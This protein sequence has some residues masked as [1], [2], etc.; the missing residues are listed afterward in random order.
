MSLTNFELEDL[1]KLLKMRVVVLL[2]DQLVNYKADT[3][4]GK[5]IINLGNLKNGGT[6]WIALQF[7]N[8]KECVYFDSFGAPPP[9]KVKAFIPKACKFAYTTHISQA[10]ESELC[11]WFCLGFLTWNSRSITK[12]LIASSNEWSNKFSNNPDFNAGRIRMYIHHW[13]P[14]LPKRLFDILMQKIIYT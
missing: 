3:K 5:Y 4:N 11:G 13:L 10:L 8:N 12:S 6:H 14:N 2:Q 1:A 9:T 7:K